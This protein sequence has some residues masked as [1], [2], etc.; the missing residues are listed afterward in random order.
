MGMLNRC[1][2][3]RYLRFSL[4]SLLILILVTAVWLSWM[5]RSAHIQRD[6]VAAVQLAGGDVYYDTVLK[7]GQW[8]RTRRRLASTWLIDHVG[9]D[10]IS[11]V[12]LV[13]LIREEPDVESVLN[14]VARLERLEDLMIQSRYTT[15]T[16][17]VC[18][19]EL[20]DLRR[21]TLVRG[22]VTG[23]GLVYVKGLARL[24]GLYLY[25][26]P[27]TD[28]GLFYLKDL[29][30][31]RELYLFGTRVTDAGVRDLQR[32]LPKLKITR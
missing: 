23:A 12:T 22:H 4:R 29:P 26:T 27:V 28:A 18:I 6:A 21:L 11:D 30:N 20:R 24:E 13:N 5:V 16:D 14:H 7:N 32:A 19:K 3:R 1:Y 10:F 9:I 8:V 2:W 31:L 25:D 15:D 17:L